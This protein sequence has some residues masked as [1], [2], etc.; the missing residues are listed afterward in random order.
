MLCLKVNDLSVELVNKLLFKKMNDFDVIFSIR[1]DDLKILFF[2]NFYLCQWYI[3]IDI[4]NFVFDLWF[5][6]YYMDMEL[7]FVLFN[8]FLGN[9]ELG[10]EIFI[11]VMLSIQFFVDGIIVYGYCLFG[12]FLVEF[13]YMCN[14]DFFVGVVIG[15]CI[16]E[17]LIILVSVGKVF[18]FCL[19]DEENVFIIF[20]LIVVYDV[21]FFWV[22]VELVWIWIY[23]EEVVFF[24]FIGLID[25]NFNDWVGL[26]YFKWVNVK[27]LDVKLFCVNVELVI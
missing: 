11:S 17:F 13:I 1:V 9:I 7:I 10:V 18:V 22:F 8:L 25:V 6:N 24:F 20:F 16:V 26:Y 19:D 27:I 3:Q 4:V 15:E 5:I 2:V 12:L 23:V 14:W 21:I